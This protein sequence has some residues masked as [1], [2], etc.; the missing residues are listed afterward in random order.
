MLKLAAV[1]GNDFVCP[2][3]SNYLHL[4]RMALTGDMALEPILVSTLL[5]ADLAVPA[6]P[7]EAF[8]L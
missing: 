8:G 7:L 6:E 2:R 4:P 5:F 3:L 1:V